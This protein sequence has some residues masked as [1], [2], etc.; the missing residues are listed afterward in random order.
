VTQGSLDGRVAIVTG[1]GRGLGRE[2]ALLFAREGA[3]VVVNDLGG[4][5]DGSGSD[6]SAAEQVA[7]EIRTA[8]GQAVADSAD[9]SNAD[10]AD[11]L[12]QH[13]IDEFGDLHVLVNNAG[14]LR[15]RML[16][17]MSDA[18]WDDVVRVHLRGHFLPTR[19]AARHWRARS[20]AGDDVNA[21]LIN[22]SSTSGLFGNR[23]QTNYGAAKS[24]LATFTMICD[25]ELRQYG[26]RCNA[27]APNARTRLTE[28]TPGL[29]DRIKAVPGEFDRFDPANVS[30]FVAYLATADC[31]ISGKVFY[32]HG[33]GVH[34]FQPWTLVDKIETDGRWAV[35]ELQEAAAHWADV[36]FDVGKPY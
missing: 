20:K 4:S 15:D 16:V 9:V 30:P 32:V 7:A 3:C 34:L 22:T 35:G 23:G 33:S 14:I 5:S 19:A 36:E 11:S 17:N 27:I 24:G 31:R 10:G 13:A 8:G 1:A 26:V 6:G 28:A 29:S 12:V 2:H 21:S 18:E 25:L